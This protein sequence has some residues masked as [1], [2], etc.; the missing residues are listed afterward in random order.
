MQGY[1]SALCVVGTRS[2]WKAFHCDGP[3][4][5]ANQR[6]LV[7]VCRDQYESFRRPVLLHAPTS[8]GR[9]FREGLVAWNWLT[10]PP[11]NVRKIPVWRKA[12]GHRTP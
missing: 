2:F 6:F 11:A 12:L 10:P 5:R 7:S 9:P 8:H 3:T 4:G 1:P